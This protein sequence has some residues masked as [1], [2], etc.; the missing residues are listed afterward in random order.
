M[1]RRRRAM[2]SEQASIKKRSGHIRE[3]I[4]AELING[5]V[6]SGQGKAD[7]IDP[8]ENRYSIKGAEWW[9]IF[10]YA[11]NRFVTNTE[12]LEIGNIA[13]LII[14]CLDAFPE[15]KEEYD[16]DV[17]K[18]AAKRMLQLAMRRLKAELCLPGMFS[19]FL[20]KGMFDGDRVDYF[21]VLEH[22]LSGEHIPRN[23]KHFHV[24]SASEVVDVL[25]TQLVVDNS[26]AQG[27]GQMDALKVIF[28]YKGRN[29]GELEIRVDTSHYRKARWRFN[30]DLIIGILRRYI[31]ESR[32]VNNQISVYGRAIHDL[33]EEPQ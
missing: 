32:L 20:S 11:R 22:R 9:Q 31:R 14:E 2:T 23:Q 21:A 24:F 19:E 33:L 1:F 12:F 15:T 8:Q 27:V 18:T 6:I 4:F 17:N 13:E 10:M 16:V 7:V 26:T 28:L 30:S 29:T 5:D 25:S 3:Q